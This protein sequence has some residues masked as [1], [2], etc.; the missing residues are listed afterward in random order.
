MNSWQESARGQRQD[1]AAGLLRL[2]GTAVA[3]VAP[4]ASVEVRPGAGHAVLGVR[5]V[6]QALHERVAVT[7]ERVTRLL[8]DEQGDAAFR[9]LAGEADHGGRA[10]SLRI[11]HG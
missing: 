4:T 2:H 8:V 7:P 6:A 5:H 10:E 3:G 1:L 11:G 9:G